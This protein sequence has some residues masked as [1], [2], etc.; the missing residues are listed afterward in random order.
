MYQ[1]DDFE[2][3]SLSLVEE[4]ALLEESDKGRA[5]SCLCF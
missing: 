3:A 4:I 2:F 5:L 1:A